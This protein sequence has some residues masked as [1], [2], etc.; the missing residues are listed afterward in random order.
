M[1][2]AVTTAEWE[3][4]GGF[5]SRLEYERFVRWLD[6]QLADGRAVEEPVG[7]PRYAGGTAFAERWLRQPGARGPWR[8][9]EPDAPF[10]G[11]FEPVEGAR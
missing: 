2:G 5:T 7:T 4:I 8:L 6:E 11:V 1:E 10:R 3:P 9:V